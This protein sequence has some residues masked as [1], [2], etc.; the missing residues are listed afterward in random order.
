MLL[1]TGFARPA[2]LA[3]NRPRS[4]AVHAG[5]HAIFQRS[6]SPDAGFE[7]S[8]QRLLKA[9]PYN[10][11]SPVDRVFYAWVQHRAGE[12]QSSTRVARSFP[13]ELLTDPGALAIAYPVAFDAIVSRESRRSGVPGELLLAVIREESGF[14]PNALSPRGARGLMQMIPRTARRMALSS[15]LSG[16]QLIQLFV[17][18]ISIRLGAHYLR[19][20]LAAQLRPTG[21]PIKMTT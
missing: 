15:G 2:A 18:E 3:P 11:L 12:L 8:A 10:A 14:D 7:R 5:L 21:T 13:A 19:L 17:P 6:C 1:G 4:R 9:L 16:F 20:L